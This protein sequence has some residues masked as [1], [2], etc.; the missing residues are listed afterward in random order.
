MGSV[1]IVLPA[2]RARV[3]PVMVAVLAALLEVAVMGLELPR[4]RMPLA[5]AVMP[6]S[7]H[8]RCC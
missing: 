1:V 6:D 5:L 3:P 8:H 7:L 4:V 2:A